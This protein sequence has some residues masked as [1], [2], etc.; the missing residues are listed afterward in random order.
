M[1][2]I[3]WPSSYGNRGAKNV[4]FMRCVDS[5]KPQLHEMW[6]LG[7]NKVT[8]E[9]HKTAQVEVGAGTVGQLTT[10]YLAENGLRIAIIGQLSINGGVQFLGI[11][12]FFRNSGLLSTE[13]LQAPT[14]PTGWAHANTSNNNWEVSPGGPY[15]MW[16]VTWGST[17]P[18][19][20]AYM[21]RIPDNP[22][23][24]VRRVCDE[25]LCQMRRDRMRITTTSRNPIVN[26]RICRC[27]EDQ[28]GP[29]TQ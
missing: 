2:S 4:D 20:L 8:R 5:Q 25:F 14:V 26:P 9:I 10:N 28:Q 3:S 29:V 19:S 21:P 12:D 18:S 1:G 15:I 11:F 17:V 7:L 23:A 16:S 24:A 27:S 13:N 22:R 6:C